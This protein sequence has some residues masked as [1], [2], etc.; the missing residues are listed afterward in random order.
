MLTNEQRSCY[1]AEPA[2]RDRRYE[3]RHVAVG[4]VESAKPGDA[5]RDALAERIFAATVGSLELLH[6]YIGER[7]GLYQ[8]LADHKAAISPSEMAIGAKISERYATEWLEQQAVAGVL[9]VEAPAT[10]GSERRYR[11]PTGHAEVLLDRDSL[12]YVAPLAVSV[13]AIAAILPDILEAFRS[14]GGVAYERYGADMRESIANGNRPM[15]LHLLG[16]QWLPAI[17]EL[18][19]RLRSEPPARV[20]DIG[21]GSG[22]SSLAI[23]RAYPKV[24]V[25]GLDLDAASIAE[26][27]KNA[28]GC[29]LGDRVTFQVRNAGDPTLAG[30]YDLVTA[31]ETIHDMADPVGALRAMH[32][33]A[34]P[35]GRVLIG[36]EKVAEEFSAPGDDL[37]RYMYGWSALHCL[38]AGMFE[39]PSAGTGTVMRPATLRRYA[40]D[41]GFSKVDILPI[42]HDVWRF[43]LLSV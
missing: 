33:L 11:L 7:L 26:A 20:A 41:A 12:H 14:G 13:A 34:T 10:S 42:E 36:D 23:A 5:Q 2:P 17:P 30:D 24:R 38:P 6:L 25:D 27:R 29:D 31:F 43:Y 19:E 18:D 3:V 21:C 4:P 35:A 8:V 16:S 22:W 39:S 15:F 1:L 40:T 32:A 28:A 37:E 9:D